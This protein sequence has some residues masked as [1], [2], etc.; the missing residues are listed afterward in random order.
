MEIHGIGPVIGSV[1][2][3]RP[4][5]ASATAGNGFR[6]ADT[7][8][9]RLPAEAQAAV[10]ASTGVAD[11]L[12]AEGRE[13]HYTVDERSG[14]LRVELRDASGEVLRDVSPREALGLT[15]QL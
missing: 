7:T 5:R 3:D 14:R 1:G 9:E 12:A 15:G 2:T 6:L 13:L 4:Q 10:A 11:A 8:S